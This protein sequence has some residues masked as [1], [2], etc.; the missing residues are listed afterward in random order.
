MAAIFSAGHLTALYLY[1]LPVFQELIPPQ[2][3]YARLFGMTAIIRTNSTQS[4]IIHLHHDLQWP[5]FLNPLILLLMY[6]TLVMLLDQWNQIPVVYCEQETEKDMA[7]SHSK[8]HQQLD[9]MLWP[10]HAEM[11]QTEYLSHNGWQDLPLLKCEHLQGQ[12]DFSVPIYS[13][14]V[15]TTDEVSETEETKEV[16]EK[17][18]KPGGLVVLGEFLMRQS[19]VSALIVMMIWSITYNSWLTFVLLLWSCVIWMMRDRRRYAM[20]SAPFLALYANILV[21]QNFFVGLSLSQEELFP[22]IP[23]AILI[24]FDLKPYTLPCT[25]LMVKVSGLSQHLIGQL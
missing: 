13:Q 5:V 7:A 4:W 22:G 19:Y 10:S 2:D 6:Y 20:L 16:P 25:H 11:L 12:T 15:D 18:A 8:E 9:G 21:I 24:D 17:E 1:Q 23:N 14:E 3:L